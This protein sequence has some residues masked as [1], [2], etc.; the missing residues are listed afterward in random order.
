M[1]GA[2]RRLSGYNGF[3]VAARGGGHSQPAVAG[4]CF[5]RPANRSSWQNDHRR[6]YLS[7]TENHEC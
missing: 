2:A 3:P 7:S 6:T 5:S 4:P 1:A